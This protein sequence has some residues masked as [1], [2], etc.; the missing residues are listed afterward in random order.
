MELKALGLDNKLL[1]KLKNNNINTVKELWS[2]SRKSL[3][4]LNFNYTEINE[5]SIKL[6]LKGLDFNRKKYK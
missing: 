1:K 6:Q 2:L 3:K 4:N 5:I